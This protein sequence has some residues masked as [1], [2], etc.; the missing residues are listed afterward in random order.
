MKKNNVVDFDQAERNAKQRDFENEKQQ[1]S[2]N[3]GGVSKEETDNAMST[4]SKATG[5]EIFLGTK[6]SPQ[7]R[8]RFAQHLQENLGYL[9]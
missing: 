4:L 3:H 5:K 6:R 8:V 9:Y 7:S 1:F 2:K